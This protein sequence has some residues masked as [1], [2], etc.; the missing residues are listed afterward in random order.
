LRKPAI[1]RL[2]WWTESSANLQQ[3]SISFTSSP[4]HTPSKH[5]KNPA[6]PLLE[7]IR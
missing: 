4:V 3:L 1:A 6:Y 5:M 2:M 7:Q